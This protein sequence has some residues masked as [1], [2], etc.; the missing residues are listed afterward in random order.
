MLTRVGGI[1]P[2]DQLEV[3]KSSTDG[4]TMIADDSW[5]DLPV[6]YNLNDHVNVCSPPSTSV[7]MS[8][9]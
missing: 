1:G 9:R 5:I 6:G 7:M 4:A 8:G 3:V 2:E